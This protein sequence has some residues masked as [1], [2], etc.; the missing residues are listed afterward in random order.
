MIVETGLVAAT[1]TNI[2]SGGRLENVPSAG[3]ITLEFE[4][5]VATAANNHSITLSMPDGQGEVP[6]QSQVATAN[7]Q[8][9][10]G[11]L[12]R[13]TKTV[14]MIPVQSGGRFSFSTTLTLYIIH[15]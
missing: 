13:N 7:A 15:I 3:V 12:D 9:V 4:A 8:S 11:V 1:N 10:A 5:S 2:L 14:L 6:L